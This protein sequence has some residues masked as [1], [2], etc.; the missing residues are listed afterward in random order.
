MWV[1]DSTTIHNEADRCVP[2]Q[3]YVV[4]EGTTHF[5]F[6]SQDNSENTFKRNFR[7]PLLQFFKIHPE[8][9]LQ[10]LSTSQ[11]VLDV[12]P[13]GEDARMP[14][15]TH[16]DTSVYDCSTFALAPF[17]L[18]SCKGEKSTQY[19]IG[20]YFLSSS[21][22]SPS[23]CTLLAIP[24]GVGFSACDRPFTYAFIPPSQVL[25]HFFHWLSRVH[26]FYTSLNMADSR[27][28]GDIRIPSHSAR[29]LAFTAISALEKQ[30]G[31]RFMFEEYRL[32][33]R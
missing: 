7:A 9:P 15:E 4:L 28:E 6:C 23:S 19:E 11:T 26:P 16:K 31:D 14:F 10:F 5:S 30:W 3:D 1:P 32:S 12:R 18:S 25:N 27:H 21:S 24:S 17:R 33:C 2:S 20:S 22:V 13:L 8:K 29:S